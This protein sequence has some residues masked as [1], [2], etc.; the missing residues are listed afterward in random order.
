MA[1]HNKKRNVGIIYELL[2]KHVSSKLVENKKAEAHILDLLT[3]T[4]SGSQAV[5]GLQ[6]REI[7][8]HVLC[9]KRE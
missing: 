5:H 1:K 3:G 6:F 8:P 4:A 7:L 2:L 9:R